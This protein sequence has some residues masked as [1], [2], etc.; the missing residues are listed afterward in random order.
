MKQDTYSAIAEYRNTHMKEASKDHFQLNQLHDIIIKKVMEISM[1]EIQIRY[2][3]LPSPFSLF[4]MGSAGRFEQ[5]V[6]SDQDH[7]IIY[8]DSSP[9]AKAYFLSLG[10]EVS[11][12]LYQ[13]GYPY[14]DGGVM[15]GNP[16]WCKSQ[17]EWEKQILN[18]TSES[19]WESLRYLLIFIDGRSFYGQHQFMNQLKTFAYQTVQK[20]QILARIYKNTHHFKKGIGVLGQ[21]LVETHGEHAGSLNIKETAL[22]PYINAVRLLAIRNHVLETSTLSRLDQLQIHDK[23]LYKTMFLKLLT[24]RLQFASQLDY[25]SGH[26]LPVEK[27]TKEQ[28]NEMKE[29]IRNGVALYQFAGKLIEKE[30]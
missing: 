9:E 27:L 22:F 19:S 7:G 26:Y 23:H 13:V 29:I 8:L 10:K 3:P 21:L 1:K 28:K 2:G 4:V 12:G 6:W 25:E 11:K 30:G 5:S 16:F 15:S 24:Y 14:C 20:E 17:T 18:W